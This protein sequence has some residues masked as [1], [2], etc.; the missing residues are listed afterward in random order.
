MLT[1][2]DEYIG[3]DKSKYDVVMRKGVWENR[4]LDDT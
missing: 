2:L 3:F 4:G 1:K